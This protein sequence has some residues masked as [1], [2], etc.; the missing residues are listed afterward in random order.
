M[1]GWRE[2]GRYSSASLSLSSTT[3]VLPRRAPDAQCGGFAAGQLFPD[4]DPTW[5]GASSDIFV[6]EAVSTPWGCNQ[7]AFARYFPTSVGCLPCWECLI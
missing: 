4:N 6:K 2:G 7:L 5:K 3:A 1:H